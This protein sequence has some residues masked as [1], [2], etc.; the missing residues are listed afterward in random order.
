MT[1]FSYPG[2]SVEGCTLVSCSGANPPKQPSAIFYTIQPM[3]GL[4]S[5]VAKVLILIVA[6]DSCARSG[7][8][9]KSGQPSKRR[10]YPAYITWDQFLAN[11]ARLAD[12]ASDFARR[13]HGAPRQGYALLAGLVVCGRCGYQM[14]VTYKPQQRYT[15][16]ALAAGYGA[17]T[18]LHVDCASLEGVVVEAVFTALAP[19]E[20]DLL[21][22]VLAARRADVTRLAQ[23]R[24]DQ[25][26]RAEYEAQLA[27]RHYQAVDPDN[28]LVVAELER[29]S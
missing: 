25:V 8:R 3:Q 13:A 5:M 24:A 21:E 16:T 11:Q 17:A 2:N 23:L 14:R 9:W 10:V 26:A 22:E 29:R 6:L 19:A 12:N 15:C 4:S 27:Q 1:A 18:C 7:V 28:R 20:L